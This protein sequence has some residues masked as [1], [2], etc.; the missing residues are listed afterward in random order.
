MD[1]PLLIAFCTDF[2]V[3]SDVAIKL[4]IST[5]KQ[6]RFNVDIVHLVEEDQE[7]ENEHLE[8]YHKEILHAADGQHRIRRFLFYKTEKEGLLEHLNEQSY[9]F[10]IV[11]LNGLG[12]KQYS[13]SFVKYLYQGI[14]TDLVMLPF[15]HISRIRYR[16]LLTLEFKNIEQLYLIKQYRRYFSKF[17][18]HLKLFVWNEQ[19]LTEKEK[20]EAQERI[21]HILPNVNFDF[22]CVYGKNWENA[23]REEL[24]R[25]ELEFQFYFSGDIFDQKMFKSFD[26]GLISH[27]PNLTFFKIFCDPE[28]IEAFKAYS[29]NKRESSPSFL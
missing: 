28:R 27:P 26:N 21:I 3:A 6:F 19:P 5:I 16:G 10:V 1:K 2:S 17:N 20:Y 13:G 18:T 22:R 4:A 29:N 9:S 11:G 8:K 12:G 14:S 7:K 24:Q 15:E 25:N 23:Y